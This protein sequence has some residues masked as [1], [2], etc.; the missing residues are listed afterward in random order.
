M[1]QTEKNII[2]AVS[3]IILTEGFSWLGVNRIAW[4]DSR[5]KVLI[6]RYFGGFESLIARWAKELHRHDVLLNSKIMK[7]FVILLDCRRNMP[8]RLKNDGD[9]IFKG[10]FASDLKGKIKK[11]KR[12]FCIS[13]LTCFLAVIVCS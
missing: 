6:Y 5:D 10:N 2:D 13:F 3:S 11:V 7:K 1:K 8:V 12:M 4:E 9:A